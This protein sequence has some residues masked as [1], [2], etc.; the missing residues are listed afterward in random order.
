M[1]NEAKNWFENLRDEL[2][3][4]T[5]VF[6]KKSFNISFFTRGF[7]GKNI[8]LFRG[9]KY[10]DKLYLKKDFNSINLI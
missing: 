3:K 6:E 5:Q 1:F 9:I 7:G 4:Q 8:P 2:V 10:Y